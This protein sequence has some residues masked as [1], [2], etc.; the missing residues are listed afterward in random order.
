MWYAITRVYNTQIVTNVYKRVL[1][2]LFKS[3]I[4]SRS[5]RLHGRRSNNTYPV[6]TYAMSTTLEISSGNDSVGENNISRKR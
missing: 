6:R 5:R 2:R 4:N 1:P 3:S